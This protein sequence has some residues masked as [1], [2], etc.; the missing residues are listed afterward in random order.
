MGKYQEIDGD[1]VKMFQNGELDVIAHGCNCYATMGAGIAL[2]IGKQFPD[3]K[4]A[5]EFSSMKSGPVRLG[6]LT[7]TEIQVKNKDFGILFNLYTQLNPGRDFR[8]SAFKKSL[9]AMK[10]VIREQFQYYDT[11]DNLVFEPSEIKI[12]L[13]LIGC[14]IAG[15][16][17]NLVSKEVKK[18]LSEFDVT[19][20]HFKQKVVGVNYFPRKKVASSVNNK[21]LEEMTDKEFQEWLNL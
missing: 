2:T 20:V 11:E 9:E 19:I 17:W 16:D 10:K 5:D 3:A 7:W 18:I 21:K 13:P 4:L 8:M 12:G 14:G 15:G 6:R 1:L